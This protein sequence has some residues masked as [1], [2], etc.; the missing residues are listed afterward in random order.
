MQKEKR[1]TVM[2]T[3]HQRLSIVVIAGSDT[4]GVQVEC[5]Y[6]THS[7]LEEESNISRQIK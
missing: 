1:F 7:F 2:V 3:S 5:L 6:G 4:V